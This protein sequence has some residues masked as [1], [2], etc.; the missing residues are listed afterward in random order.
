MSDV[1]C[2]YHGLLKTD[3]KLRK[4]HNIKVKIDD[5]GSSKRIH[6]IAAEWIY[7]ESTGLL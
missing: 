7:Y 2:V 1:Y 3:K 5:P 4:L 6:Q